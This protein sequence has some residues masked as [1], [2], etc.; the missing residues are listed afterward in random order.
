MYL[1]LCVG[2]MRQIGMICS[3]AVLL[4]FLVIETRYLLLKTGIEISD[5]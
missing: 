2:L 4:R 1:W 3:D 5:K